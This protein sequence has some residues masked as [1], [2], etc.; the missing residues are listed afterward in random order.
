MLSIMCIAVMAFIV[1]I[2]VDIQSAADVETRMYD[3]ASKITDSINELR[4]E[5]R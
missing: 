4:L 1:H 2:V 5:D 3:E